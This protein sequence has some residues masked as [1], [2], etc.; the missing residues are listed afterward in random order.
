MLR[1]PLAKGG[2][3]M[4]HPNEGRWAELRRRTVSTPEL[5]ERYERTRLAVIRTRQTLQRIDEERE[6]QG[7]SKAELARR[8]GMSP[9]VVR[10]L[11]SSPSSNPTLETV[12][13][14]LEELD[15]E[16]ELKPRRARPVR[17]QPEGGATNSPR[18]A[19][20]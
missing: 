9:V 10:R 7:L 3:T 1:F 11:F 6:R 20:V 19:I 15:I 16:V 17:R 18:R 8:T 2:Y 14:L 4:E 5:K 12:L 13:S